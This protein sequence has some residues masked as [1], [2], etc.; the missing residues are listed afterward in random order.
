MMQLMEE[1]VG[2][3]SV[4]RK[5]SALRGFFQFRTLGGRGPSRAHRLDRSAED[6]ETLTRIR[7]G[8]RAWNACWST[9]NGLL[10]TEGPPTGW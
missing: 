7:G 9:W 4:N 1:G 3:R 10:D 5:L 2:A 6:P 8:E